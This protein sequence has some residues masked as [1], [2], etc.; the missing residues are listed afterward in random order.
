LVLTGA[1]FEQDINRDFLSRLGPSGPVVDLAGRTSLLEL[2]G[3]I[4]ACRLFISSDSGPYHMA[5]GLRV[6]TL[7]LFR[8]PSP[9]HYHHYAWVESQVARGVEALPTL[10]E[11]AERL[12]RV[13]PPSLP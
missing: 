3:A 11:A 12:M 9:Q 13:Q 2:T 8:W 5:V 7:A 6:P 10:L 4:A 1:A